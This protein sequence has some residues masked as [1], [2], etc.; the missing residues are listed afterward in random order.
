MDVDGFA[1]LHSAVGPRRGSCHPLVYLDLWVWA[2]FE[3]PLLAE[4]GP[5][6]HHPVGEGQHWCQLIRNETLCYK[7]FLDFFTNGISARN[8]DH[9]CMQT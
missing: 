9:P 7:S 3:P 6:R 2:V 1:Y 4:P 8:A 5:K